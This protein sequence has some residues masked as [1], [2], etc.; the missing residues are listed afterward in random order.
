MMIGSNFK[1]KQTSKVYMRN[2]HA[3]MMI[4]NTSILHS[5][6]EWLIAKM[7]VIKCN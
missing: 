6:P 7:N 4:K 1:E 3:E 2:R 5:T